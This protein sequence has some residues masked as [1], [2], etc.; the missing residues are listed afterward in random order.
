MKIANSKTEIS[1]EVDFEFEF[2]FFLFLPF[3]A[4]HFDIFCMVTP[5]K[6]LTLSFYLHPTWRQTNLFP[7][8]EL[9][10]S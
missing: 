2:P 6:P 7:T 9:G 8:D 5:Y 3:F 4:F 1:H 10:V